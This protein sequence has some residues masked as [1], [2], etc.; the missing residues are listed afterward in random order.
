[1][2]PLLCPVACSKWLILGRTYVVYNVRYGAWWS[3]PRL[4][5]CI[6]SKIALAWFIR[7]DMISAQLRSIAKFTIPGQKSWW[8]IENTAKIAK[9]AHRRCLHNC[10]YLLNFKV[11]FGIELQL[12]MESLIPSLEVQ[13]SSSAASAIFWS[14]WKVKSFQNTLFP[15]PTSAIFAFFEMTLLLQSTVPDQSF[16]PCCKNQRRGWEIPF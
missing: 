5:I 12:D 8:N 1:M 7:Y 10:T 14:W 3:M 16:A 13:S 15:I 6:P 4:C 11:I 9:S 2:I